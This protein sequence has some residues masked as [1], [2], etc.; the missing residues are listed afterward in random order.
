VDLS[1]IQYEF[2]MV[3][4]TQSSLLGED[5]QV[6]CRICPSSNVSKSF[7]GNGEKEPRRLVV[8]SD[9]NIGVS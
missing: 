7:A 4:R 9:K 5:G 1:R 2:A 3:P 8:E 6:A